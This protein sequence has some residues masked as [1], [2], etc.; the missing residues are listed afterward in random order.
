[1]A[2]G[3]LKPDDYPS[4]PGAELIQGKQFFFGSARSAL[5]RPSLALGERC[6]CATKLNDVGIADVF[7][8]R[9]ADL[10]GLEEVHAHARAGTDK[11]IERGEGFQGLGGQVVFQSAGIPLSPLFGYLEHVAQKGNEKR[12]ASQDPP[13]Q[14]QTEIRQLHEFVSLV[15]HEPVP[16]ETMQRVGHAGVRDPLSCSD[17]TNASH[18]LFLL[19]LQDNLEIV[20]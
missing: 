7:L 12:V 18:P 1:M 3:G 19:Q 5:L 8:S 2:E 6:V 10:V 13:G 11:L 4:V 14:V 15:V 20:F 9:A 16:R 17:V